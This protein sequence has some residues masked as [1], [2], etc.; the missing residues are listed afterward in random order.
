[1]FKSKQDINGSTRLNKQN[2]SK[3]KKQ[4]KTKQQQ[5]QKNP[6]S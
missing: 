3:K 4:Q 2:V 6:K 1:M 5:Q